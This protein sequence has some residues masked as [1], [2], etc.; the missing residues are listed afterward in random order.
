MHTTIATYTR[1]SLSDVEAELR[2]VAAD[3]LTT[4]GTLTTEHLNWRPDQKRWSVA[5]CL[6]H[7]VTTNELMMEAA[8]RALD[9]RTPR[10]V[11]QRVPGVPRL[12]GPMLIRS[13]APTST[14]RFVAPAQV[15]PS[16]SQIDAA[17]VARFI[18]QHDAAVERLQA[19]D[20]RTASRTIM[21]SPFLRYITYSVLDGWRLI[22]AHDHRHLE[23]AH[24]AMVAG[25]TGVRS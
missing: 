9:R 14:R 7:L 8:E 4:F 25:S 24:R 3:T 21:V 20:E 18:A 2:I 13:Q 12:L 11:W 6:E 5:Q 22:L 23:Q 17:V 15:Q 1:L 10:T 19:L 16:A